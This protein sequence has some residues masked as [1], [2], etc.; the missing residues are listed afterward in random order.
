MQEI[1]VKLRIKDIEQ[2]LSILRTA[3]CVFGDPLS[4]VDVVYAKDKSSMKSFLANDLFLR[5]RVNNGNEIIFTLKYDNNRHNV[6]FTKI[7]HEVTVS[8]QD[9]MEAMLALLG[10]ERI[11][12]VR[13]TRWKTMYNDYEIC[14]DEVEELGSFLEIE[15]LV[16]P[17]VD[18]AEV[19]EEL[20]AVLTSLGIDL[21]GRVNRGYDIL[22]LEHEGFA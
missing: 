1:E 14:V 4:Q 10:F 15:K 22:K 7:E 18:A 13:K 2:A 5:I 21:S 17:G 11:V 3:G 12:E 19:Q 16:A 9:E 20:V 8:S 6:D